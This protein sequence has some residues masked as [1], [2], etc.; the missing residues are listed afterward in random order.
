MLLYKI[1]FSSTHIPG[2]LKM[3]SILELR[4]HQDLK[5]SVLDFAVRLFFL[6]KMSSLSHFI[7]S[8]ERID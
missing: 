8:T 5:W 1:S 7:C 4:K 6:A 3:K 2:S